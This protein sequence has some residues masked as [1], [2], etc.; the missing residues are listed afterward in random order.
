MPTWLAI[1]IGAA[2]TLTGVLATWG[3]LGL[4][5]RER[6]E[7]KAEWKGAVDSDRKS[8][9]DFMKEIRKDIT[10]L[11]DE[12]RTYF[13]GKPLITPG[14]PLQLTGY[15]KKLS[16]ELD[17]KKWAAEIATGLTDQLGGADA[18]E[19]QQFSFNHVE[20]IEYTAEQSKLIRDIAYRNGLSEGNVRRVLAIEL[21]DKLLEMA[22][23]LEA[24]E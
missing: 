6:W 11:R 3:T 1:L 20:D 9:K 12:F 17:G 7:A 10:A 24:P 13:G 14:S 23:G 21:R 18:Y 4:K 19:I 16:E 5:I 15:G 2:V 22:G 8:F